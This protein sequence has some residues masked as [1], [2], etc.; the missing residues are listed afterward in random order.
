MNANTTNKLR[1]ENQR[2]N[3]LLLK[4]VA[5]N[6]FS[7]VTKLKTLATLAFPQTFDTF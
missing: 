6:S 4:S 3:L 7:F 1:A 2:A 5:T